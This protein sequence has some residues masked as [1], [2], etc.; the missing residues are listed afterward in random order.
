MAKQLLIETRMNS[1]GLCE[2][3]EP[4]KNCLGTLYGPC[5]DYKNST[6]NGNFYSRKLWENVFNDDIVKESLDDRILIGELDH[7][8]DRLETKATNACIVMTGYEFHDDEGLLYGSFDIL[9]TP[10][11]RILKSLLDY[12]CKVGVSSRGEGDVVTESKGDVVDEDGY[13]FVGFDA[14]VLPAV[15]AAKPTLREGLDREGKVL[16]LKESLTKEVESATS[17][18]ELNLIKSVVEATNLPDAGSLL[19]SVNI[20]SQELTEGTTGSSDNL[21]EDLEKATTQISTLTKE[22]SSLKEELATCKSRISKQITS[23]QKLIKESR[24]QKEKLGALESKYNCLVFEAS[25]STSEVESLKEELKKSKEK[26][27]EL[28]QEIRTTGSDVKMFESRISNLEES[29]RKSQE[30]CQKKSSEIDSLKQDLSN[31]Q[32]KV[33]SL[34]SASEKK[35]NESKSRD[36][37]LRESLEKAKAS[38]KESR[39]QYASF[40]KSYVE[41]KCKVSGIDSSLVLE[42][43]KSNASIKEVNSLIE[44]YQDRADRY[45]SL[46]FKSDKLLSSLDK[47]SVRFSRNQFKSEDPEVT[48]TRSF[49]NEFFNKN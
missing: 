45:N 21:L 15:K 26:I 11:G 7:P 19:E 44:S 40:L 12:G 34:Q 33:E 16:T 6:R 23:R 46:P 31:S 41:E 37:K 48:Q 20:K 2:S 8:G 32:K 4:H 18:A 10:N 49:M 30:V 25:S 3:K 24:S 14:V 9:P 47:G 36:N 13:N 1:L 39:D 17:L 35:L 22:N 38:L 5:A 42:S 29:L 28:R 43:V 27:Q